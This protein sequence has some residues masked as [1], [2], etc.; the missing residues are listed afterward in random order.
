[1][2]DG[3]GRSIPVDAELQAWLTDGAPPVVFTAGSANVRSEAFFD[4]AVSVSKAL[5]LRAVL[6]TRS[7]DIVASD[8]PATMRHEAYVPFGRLLPRSRA[9][10]SHGGV[11]TCAQALA[12]GTPHVVAHM[13]FDQRDNGS[14]LED[15]GTGRA[16][17]MAKFNGKRAQKALEAVL[18]DEVVT[19]A[20]E[21]SRLVD[22]DAALD[23]T[24]QEIEAMGA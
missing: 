21:L 19:R 18:E 24:C 3:G 13:A 23:R 5:G 6:V 22:R 17:S 1:V 8:L 11:G 4:A 14:R 10:V 12:S 15:L 9:L 16:I 7:P 20:E 2:R